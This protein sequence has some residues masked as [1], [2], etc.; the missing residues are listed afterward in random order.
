MTT[1]VVTL[2]LES[3]QD[4][5]SQSLDVN[6][7]VTFVEGNNGSPTNENCFIRKVTSLTY[8][9][10]STTLYGD[11]SG[12]QHYKRFGSGWWFVGVTGN[13]LSV[14]PVSGDGLLI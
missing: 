2:G 14:T 4:P 8:V 10:H 12:I 11:G 9:S 5:Q 7:N 6:Y 13:N 1:L 3:S